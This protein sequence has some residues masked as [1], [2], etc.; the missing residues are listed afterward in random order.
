MPDVIIELAEARSPEEKFALAEGI[1]KTTV[2]TLNVQPSDVHII[3]RSTVKNDHV[4]AAALEC[5]Q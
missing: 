2:D 5:N 1:I 4:N 3:V